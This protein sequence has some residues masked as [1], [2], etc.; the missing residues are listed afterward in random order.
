MAVKRSRDADVVKHKKALRVRFKK[1]VRAV[2][3]NQTWLSDAE[4]QGISMNVKKNVALMRQK[5]KPGMLTMAV[6][7]I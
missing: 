6:S 1:L 3:M 4:E 7:P 5:R 2:I